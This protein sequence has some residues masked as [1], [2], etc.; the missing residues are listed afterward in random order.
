MQ[1]AADAD[2]NMMKFSV[3]TEMFITVQQILI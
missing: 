1:L 2:M 3:N